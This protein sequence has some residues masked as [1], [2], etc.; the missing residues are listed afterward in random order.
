[1]MGSKGTSSAWHSSQFINIISRDYWPKGRNGLWA[2][3]I[4]TDQRFR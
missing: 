1:M 2:M 4:N 3:G